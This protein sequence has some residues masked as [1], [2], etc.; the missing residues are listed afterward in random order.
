MILMI[1]GILQKILVLIII[2]CDIY[3]VYH[4]D[5]EFLRHRPKILYMLRSIPLTIDFEYSL[6]WILLINDNIFFHRINVRSKSMLTNRISF[7]M[8]TNISPILAL[9][10]CSIGTFVKLIIT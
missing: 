2:Y 4:D 6:L 1:S 10:K 5:T 7:P 8:N 9:N 3:C